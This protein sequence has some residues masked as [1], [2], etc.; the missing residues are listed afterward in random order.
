MNGTGL[1]SGVRA[2]LP[3]FGGRAIKYGYSNARVRAMKGL[4]LKS[5]FLDE[6]IRVG[7]V[8]GMA[9]LLQ[10]TGYKNELSGASVR[11]R[12]SALIET[13]A[14]WNFSRTVRKLVKITPKGDRGAL[15]ALLLRYDML[16]LKTIVH[17]RSL[18]KGFDEIRPHLIEVGGLD[19][20][21]FRRLMKADDQSFGKEMKR[22]R[23]VRELLD[24]ADDPAMRD[25]LSK[26]VSGAEAFMKMEST[27]DAY[28]YLFMDKALSKASG[29]EYPH[30]RHLLRKEIDAKNIMI[31]ERMKKHGIGRERIKASMIKGGTMPP[32]TAE[33]IMDAKDMAAM[34]QAARPLFPQPEMKEAKSLSELEIALEKS[35]AAQKLIAFHRA[36]LSAGVIIGFLLLKEEEIN[37]LRKIAKGKEFGM[38]EGEVRATLVVV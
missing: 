19:E 30:I 22:T 28:M 20:A 8:E 23:A 9:E 14:S 11:Y 31:I 24:S 1:L 17:A 18:K 15:Q 26:A 4:L 34:V 36:T 2:M 7:T 27:V 33:R 3:S 25:S 29:R 32:Q 16:N 21:D 37:N 35:I 6:M 10:R 12:G 13:A 38:S 5:G